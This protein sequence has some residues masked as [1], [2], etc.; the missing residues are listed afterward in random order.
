MTSVASIDDVDDAAKILRV[1][2]F[3]HQRAFGVL[4]S[5]AGY[6]HPSVQLIGDAG[7]QL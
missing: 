4:P 3:D 2:A 7:C 6:R 1:G 5:Q